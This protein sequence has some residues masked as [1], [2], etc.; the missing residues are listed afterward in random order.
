MCNQSLCQ[1]ESLLVALNKIDNRLKKLED[2]N[3]EN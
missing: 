3:D 1:I 2:S